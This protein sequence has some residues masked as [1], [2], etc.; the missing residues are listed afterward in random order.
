MEYMTSANGVSV[1]GTRDSRSADI[2]YSTQDEAFVEFRNNWLVQ[3]STISCFSAKDFEMYGLNVLAEYISE[4]EN[5]IE[6]DFILEMEPEDGYYENVTDRWEF[7]AD[8]TTLQIDKNNSMI[9]V[10]LTAKQH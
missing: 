7:C 9:K 1:Y 10:E 2:K 3:V 5:V 8:I 4:I 6:T